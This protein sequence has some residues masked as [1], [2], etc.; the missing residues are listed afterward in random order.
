MEQ[1]KNEAALLGMP[2]LGKGNYSVW[3]YS[4][5]AFADENDI[6]E[7]L[8]R[9]LFIP[10]EGDACKIELK[11]KAQ[12]GHIIHD[13][14]WA[15]RS[16]RRCHC[17]LHAI[18]YDDYHRQAHQT[19]VNGGGEWIANATGAGYSNSATE[20]HW[21]IC[22]EAHH[23]ATSDVEG[24]LPWHRRW[25]NQ[26]A[27]SIRG[28]QAC[29]SIE[30]HVPLLM[31][32]RPAT[33]KELTVTLEMLNKLKKQRRLQQRQQETFWKILQAGRYQDSTTTPG[34]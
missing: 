27:A 15:A 19:P 4:I 21:G 8:T 18:I 3:N 29:S 30:S 16:T 5:N 6:S 26:S 1:I 9:K 31:T 14:Q 12:T 23:S 7:Y 22:Q 24:E 20:E 2:M 11:N 17:Q 33:L 25:E 10:N 34:S 32:Q 13:E 28:L